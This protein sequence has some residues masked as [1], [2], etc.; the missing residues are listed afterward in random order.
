MSRS[1]RKHPIEKWSESEKDDK[2]DANRKL[3][4]KN[5]QKNYEDEDIH[6]HNKTREVSDNWDW[7]LDGYKNYAPNNPVAKRK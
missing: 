3:R 4:R 1:Y 7:A 5:K 2:R 6:L